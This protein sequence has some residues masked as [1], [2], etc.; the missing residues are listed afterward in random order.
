MHTTPHDT[1]THQFATEDGPSQPSSLETLL[2]RA[3]ASAFARLQRDLEHPDP[4]VARLAAA[5]LL[6]AV[7]ELAQEL[8]PGTLD[9]LLQAQPDPSPCHRATTETDSP[10]GTTRTDRRVH[11]ART[12]EPALLDA[13][14]TVVIP[15]H[16]RRHHRRP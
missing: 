6:K 8:A 5:E 10:P 9:A 15:G 11:H 3:T 7:H 12:T 4:R 1:T 2:H 14:S 16:E 13:A